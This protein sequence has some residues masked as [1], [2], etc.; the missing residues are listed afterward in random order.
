MVRHDK[1]DIKTINKIERYF[2]CHD[3]N[4]I[5][6]YFWPFRLPPKEQQVKFY[7]DFISHATLN[8]SLLEKRI[9]PQKVPLNLWVPQTHHVECVG[10]LEKKRK[11][12]GTKG[13]IDFLRN[14]IQ[15][16]KTMDDEEVNNCDSRFQDPWVFSARLWRDVAVLKTAYQRKRAKGGRKKAN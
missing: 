13:I 5:Q 4:D 6:W 8:V 16:N 11:T 7:D 15:Y 1:S 12:S 3:T 2:I 10:L 9:N 14:K